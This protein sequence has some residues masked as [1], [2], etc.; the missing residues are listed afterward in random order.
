MGFWHSTSGR[1]DVP[2]RQRIDRV[3]LDT[4]DDAPPEPGMTEGARIERAEL[5]LWDAIRDYEWV[6]MDP[7]R[8]YYLVQN[9]ADDL[10]RKCI[11]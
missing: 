9:A 3:R 7:R 8:T 10:A 6:T 5:A 11:R 4:D 1:V 2:L